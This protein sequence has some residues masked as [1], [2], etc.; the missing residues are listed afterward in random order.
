MN[1]HRPTTLECSAGL[2]HDESDDL[3]PDSLK[4]PLTRNFLRRTSRPERHNSARFRRVDATGGAT[5]PAR[6]YAVSVSR[7]RSLFENDSSGV[8]SPKFDASAS[9]PPPMMHPMKPAKTSVRQLTD[10]YAQVQRNRDTTPHPLRPIKP[11]R[12]KDCGQLLSVVEED[13]Y[14]SIEDAGSRP[15]DLELLHRTEACRTL[16]R[17]HDS[18]KTTP[19]RKGF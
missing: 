10:I 19:P 9:T 3:V 11:P 14:A 7:S 1:I 13:A 16:N 15:A 18:I 2:P 12:L 4:S 5:A 17:S 8:G 6:N